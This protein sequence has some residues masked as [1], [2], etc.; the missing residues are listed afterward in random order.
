MKLPRILFAIAL[1][2]LSDFSPSWAQDY[3][4]LEREFR[5]ERLSR[6]DKRFLQ[7]ALAFEGHYNGL[8]DGDWGRLSQR[9]LDKYAHQEFGE[10]AQD[11]HMVPLALGLA[12]R[13]DVDGWEMEF[14]DALGLSLLF[15]TKTA[16]LDEPS[17]YFVNWRHRNSSLAYSVAIS[18][19]DKASSFHDYV[20]SRHES[21]SE[22]YTVRRQGFAVSSSQARDGSSL[23]ARSNYVNGSWS[24]V[25][26]SA[27]AKDKSEL[28]AVAASIAVG[29]ARPLVPTNGGHLDWAVDAMLELAEE[30]DRNAA[31]QSDAARESGDRAG[32]GSGSGFYVSSSGHVLTNAHVIEGCAYIMVDGQPAELV[33]S[34]GNFDLALLRTSMPRGRSVATFSPGPPR[35]NSDVTVAGYPYAGV[36]GGLNITRGAVSALSGIGGDETQIQITAP[37]QSGNSGGPLVASDGEVVGVVVSKLDA[38]RVADVLGDLPQNVNFGVRGEIAKMFLSQNGVQP[39]LGITNGALEPSDLADRAVAFTAF[40]EC[41]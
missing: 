4:G 11:W 20:L 23:Y 36:L 18:D 17:E 29:R 27:S 30:N 40:V 8:L 9:A 10:N 38:V 25:I 7:A 34:S 15:P 5:A 6:D 13:Y 2:V 14:F 35:L 31:N 21:Y 37:V 3:D 16:V 1:I 39:L 26:L 41:Q 28:N 22:P 33:K 24:T 19:V 32:G 12:Q